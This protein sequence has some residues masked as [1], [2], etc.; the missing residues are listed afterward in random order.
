MKSNL[1]F[2]KIL[3]AVVCIALI[4]AA[5]LSMASCKNSETPGL[6]SDTTSEAAASANAASDNTDAS[7]SAKEP[8]AREIGEG[9]TE[10]TLIVADLEENE[11]IFTVKTDEKTVGDALVKLG[12]IEGEESEYG[13]YVK[14]VD[15]VTADYDTDQTYWA[16]YINGEYASTGVDSTDISAGASYELRISK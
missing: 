16:F 8:Q 1:N 14:T 13:L 10:F 2:K 3:S 6:S 11:K 15:G 7:E 4:A 5:V 9:A 12:L